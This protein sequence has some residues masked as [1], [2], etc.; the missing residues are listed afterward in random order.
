M[1]RKEPE[2]NKLTKGAIAGAAGIAL[3][4]GGAGTFALWNGNASIGGAAVSTG[5]LTVAADAAAGTWADASATNTG[6]TTFNPGTQK[7]VPGDVI[8]YTKKIN[9]EAVGKNIK[10]VLAAD[11]TGI[12]TATG[13]SYDMSATVLTANGGTLTPVS[14]ATNPGSYTYVPGSATGTVS[15]QVVVTVTFDS[16]T[17]G[18][19]SQGTTGVDLS[20]LKVTLTQVRP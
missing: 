11:T 19:T 13:V 7:I 8:T 5:K 1:T 12:T 3:L 4:M 6:G 18:T 2:M 10:A 9:V 14:P 16:A 17:T 20:A 15:I